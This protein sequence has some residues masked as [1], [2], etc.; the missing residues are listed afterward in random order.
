MYKCFRYFFC[1]KGVYVVSGCSGDVDN[2]RGDGQS[3]GRRV[4]SCTC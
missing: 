1:K 2:K 3:P 4:Q